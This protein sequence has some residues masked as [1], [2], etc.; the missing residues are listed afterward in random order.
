M[1]R[2]VLIKFDK[3]FRE[4]GL[5]FKEERWAQCLQCLLD[6]HKSVPEPVTEEQADVLEQP[7]FE[8]QQINSVFDPPQGVLLADVNDLKNKLAK[9]EA[10]L[11]EREAEINRLTALSI[12]A[13]PVEV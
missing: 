13:A 5:E 11:R 6:N 10:E 8:E 12:P 4:M 3:M 7:L 9:Y 1:D 2:C